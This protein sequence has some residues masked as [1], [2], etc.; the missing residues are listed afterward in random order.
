MAHEWRLRAA[1]WVRD[2]PAAQAA[3]EAMPRPLRDE[4]RWQLIRRD[5][6]F[7]AAAA[8]YDGLTGIDAVLTPDQ[9]AELDTRLRGT[10]P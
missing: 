7:E 3:L 10:T 9:I 1:L 4:T 5:P 6:V 8:R 2:W